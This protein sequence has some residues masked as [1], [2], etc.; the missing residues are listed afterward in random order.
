MIKLIDDRILSAT[1]A[2]YLSLLDRFGL[3][4]G[5]V[6]AV[7]LIGHLALS[8]FSIPVVAFKLLCLVACLQLSALQRNRQLR[9]VNA[10]AEWLRG[11]ALLR[12]IMVGLAVAHIV[13]E[14]HLDVTAAQ[15]VGLAAAYLFC[16]KVRER[17]TLDV[18]LGAIR[19]DFA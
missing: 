14:P 1:Q 2:V 12:L 6:L 7:L 11:M 19:P 15:V 9:L 4:K 16:A 8:P 13:R 3:M 5:D 10:T 18:R 17:R